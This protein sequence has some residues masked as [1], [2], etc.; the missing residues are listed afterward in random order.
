MLDTNIKLS[1]SRALAIAAMVIFGVVSA[2]NWINSSRAKERSKEWLARP[3]QA[4]VHLDGCTAEWFG[5]V[6]CSGTRPQEFP[7]PETLVWTCDYNG[8]RRI[9]C[10]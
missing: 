9:W 7:S 3:A 5:R 4:K 2:G 1:P 6:K 10:E 8:C